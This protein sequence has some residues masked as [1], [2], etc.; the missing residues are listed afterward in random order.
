M[1]E[2][3]GLEAGKWAAALNAHGLMAWLFAHQGDE[4]LRGK[5]VCASGCVCVRDGAASAAGHISA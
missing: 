3:N 2:G 4:C 1:D 5:C